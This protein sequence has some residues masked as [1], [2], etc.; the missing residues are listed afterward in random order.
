LPTAPFIFPVS[1]TCEINLICLLSLYA[2]LANYF[3][4]VVGVAGCPWVLANIASL[5]HYPLL[6]TKSC[7]ILFKLGIITSLNDS[8]NINE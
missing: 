4:N 3:P 2:K 6:L 8:D 1:L 7:Y 5:A